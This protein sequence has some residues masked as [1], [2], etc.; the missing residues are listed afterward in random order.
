MADFLRNVFHKSRITVGRAVDLEEIQEGEDTTPSEITSNI[1]QEVE[2]FE[3]P[4]PPSENYIELK[5]ECYCDAGFET[6]RDDT[7]SQTGYVFVLNG[8]AVD[9][10]SS[11]QITRV[12]DEARMLFDKSPVKDIV[13]WTAMINGYI[14]FNHV[15]TLSRE[16][17]DTRDMDHEYMN[18]HRIVIH[19]VCG[20]ALIDMYAKCGC[21]YKSLEVFYGLHDKDTASWTSIICAL[22]VNGKTME[23]GWY[24]AGRLLL[25]EAERKVNRIPKEK[26]DILVPVYGALL[27]ACRLYGDVGKQFARIPMMTTKFFTYGYGL[28]GRIVKF[29]KLCLN[30]I[31]T[32]KYEIAKFKFSRNVDFTDIHGMMNIGLTSRNV[33]SWI[34]VELSNATGNSVVIKGCFGHYQQVLAELEPYV[35]LAEKCRFSA[36]ERWSVICAAIN[37]DPVAPGVSKVDS[38]KSLQLILLG[39][40]DQN[41]VCPSK[42]EQESST[43]LPVISTPGVI[44]KKGSQFARMFLRIEGAHI[45]NLSAF[46]APRDTWPAVCLILIV[47]ARNWERFCAWNYNMQSPGESRKVKKHKNRNPQTRLAGSKNQ[48]NRKNKHAYAPKPKIPPPPKREDPAKDSICHECGETGHWK[49][50]CPQ[51]LAELLKKKKNTASGAGGGSAVEAI[52]NFDLSLPSGLVIV[53]NNCHYAPSI[54]RGV[55]SVSRLYEDGFINRFVNN[56]IQVSRNNMVYF[57]A[58]PRDG[59]FEIDLSNSYTNENSIYTVS[60]KRAKL[61]LDS[62]LLWHCRL[63]HISKKRIELYY[64]TM[65]SLNSTDLRAFEKCVPCMSGK[66]AR[67]PY[68]HQ[69]ERAKDL[70]GLIHTDVCG[71]F[72]ITSRQGASY[73]VTFTD[74]FSRYGYVYLL[75][76]K[77]EV[78]ETFNKCFKRIMGLSPIVL[79]RTLHTHNGVSGEEKNRTLL[80]MVRSMIVTTLPKSFWDY[81]LE[82]AARI[83]NM[84]LPTKK[85]EKTHTRSTRTRHA[86]DRMCLYVNAEEH[87]F[88]DLG[89]PANYKAALLDPE[90]DK[91]L[92]VMNVEM[93]SMKDNEVWV[94]VDLPPNGKTVGSKWFFKKKT[95]M[96]GVNQDEPC[97]Y[98]KASGSNITFLILYVDDI[99]I[100]GNNIPMMQGVKSYLG[101]CFAMKDLREAAYIFLESRSTEIDHARGVMVTFLSLY[102]TTSLIMG[103]SNS[104]VYKM[105]NPTWKVFCYERYLVKL[106]IFWNQ[107]HRDRSDDDKLRLSKSQGASTPAE[108]KRMQSVPYASALVS[109]IMLLDVLRPDCCG[110]SEHTQPIKVYELSATPTP[111]WELL[112][113][114]VVGLARSRLELGLDTIVVL[115][116]REVGLASGRACL[117]VCVSTGRGDNLVTG[118]LILG[119]F[120]LLV[121]TRLRHGRWCFQIVRLLADT[122]R[123]VPY[124]NVRLKQ[125]D[126]K[127]RHLIK[128]SRYHRGLKRQ[129]LTRSAIER[130]K[131]LITEHLDNFKNNATRDDGELKNLCSSQNK[132]NNMGNI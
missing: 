72:K 50:N 106:H 93:Q 73:F 9:W 29:L 74:D 98:L 85:V 64:I 99:L 107:D 127:A 20:T 44:R 110:R 39:S 119:L 68:T 19:A 8:G 83:L 100:M 96:D 61:D 104:T 105:L 121:T 87:E 82:T 84:G 48:G 11:K 66:M 65:D 2:G 17:L 89:E 52:G 21:I 34:V 86:P 130:G 131:K 13:L 1:P 103:N 46:G 117:R 115:D 120:D 45:D 49:R 129:T 14:Q 79:L 31:P 102:S 94:L 125:A 55:I 26:D 41:S 118:F 40:K 23:E 6:D 111:K 57:S 60:N 30:A 32:L 25:K 113:Y 76:H 33:T 112:D 123:H 69:V 15:C 63:G 109:I 101:K 51:Y 70:L 88:G 95:N 16:V 22:S 58:I 59:I 53:L 56:T 92:N 27:S 91:W 36:G 10:K 77:H 54:T 67:K 71:P 24:L 3:P 12:S 90:S 42:H 97:V 124:L 132:R 43:D 126:V 78:F 108:L 5:V 114:M 7:K 80:D 47:Y 38:L 4:Q 18:E 122:V 128:R 37:P 35:T 28:D 75:K 62:A 81:A 116:I